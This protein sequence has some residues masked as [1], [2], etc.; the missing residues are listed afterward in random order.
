MLQAL[1]NLNVLAKTAMVFCIFPFTAV[2]SSEL[3]FLYLG[4]YSALS[5]VRP[6]GG[7]SLE[8]LFLRMIMYSLFSKQLFACS[9][10]LLII[11]T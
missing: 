4:I 10:V 6:E 5:A 3:Q 8:Q 9:F 1:F 7:F 11:R 2:K